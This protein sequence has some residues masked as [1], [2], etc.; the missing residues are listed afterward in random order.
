VVATDKLI[1]VTAISHVD[2]NLHVWTSNDGGNVWKEGAPLNTAGKSARE[3]MHAMA[4]DGVGLVVAVWLDDRSGGKEL[5]SRVSRDGGLN[6]QPEARVYASRDGHICECC[7]PSVAVG[8]RGEVAAM[9]RNWLEGSRDM[10]LAMSADGGQTF[11]AAQKLGTGTWKLNGCPM[12]GGA[13]TLDATGKPLAVWRRE[14]TV[15]ISGEGTA[16]QVLAS[17][18]SQPVVSTAKN[19]PLFVWEQDGGLMLRRGASGAERLAERATAPAVGK[20]RE[21]GAVVLWESS[22]TN[23][24]TIVAEVLR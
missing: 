13:V 2:G 17:P 22:A 10:W 7:H 19:G 5:W 11:G 16:E 1:T 3:G 4:G 21:G 24:P 23:P 14:K 8:P 6:W 18:A 12:D 15:F 20:T 9:W